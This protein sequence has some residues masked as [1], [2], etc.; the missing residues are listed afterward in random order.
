MNLPGMSRMGRYVALAYRRQ[1]RLKRPNVIGPII[2]K[3][4]LRIKS[5]LQE[6][7]FRYVLIVL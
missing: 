7:V 5:V 1:I 2:F 4:I 6:R 3:S